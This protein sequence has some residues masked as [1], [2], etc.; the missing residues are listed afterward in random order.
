MTLQQLKYVIL[1]AKH[2]TVSK[3]ANEAFISQPSLSLAIKELEEEIGIKIFNR[4]NKGLTVT[5]DGDEFLSYARQVV[6]QYQMIEYKYIDKK[7]NKNEHFAVSTQH[8]SFAV[9]A[10]MST[11]KQFNSNDFEFAIRETKTHEVIEDVKTLRSEIG[12]LY[13]SHFNKMVLSKLFREYNLSFTPL[14]N[15]QIYVYLHEDNPL[16]N[17]DKI[18]LEMLEDYP[19]LS[20]EQGSHNSFFF[21]EEV[22]STHS[23]KQIIRVNDRATMLNLMQGLQ[24]F[25][26]CSGII[27]DELNGSKYHAVPLVCDEIMQ[28][29]Y[30]HKTNVIL[31]EIAQVYIDEIMKIYRNSNS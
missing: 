8:Y 6:E 18:T 10:F 28:V 31:S 26:L 4:S 5:A 30:I 12:V 3:A 13:L 7:E 9:K 23:Y 16:L 15:C 22:L 20:F 21:T 27:A 19:C 25:T 29:G 24:G 11:I 1:T 14:F 17:H 2:G